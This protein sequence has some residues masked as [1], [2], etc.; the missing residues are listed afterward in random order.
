MGHIDELDI[1]HQCKGQGQSQA[2]FSSQGFHQIKE[3]HQAPHGKAPGDQAEGEDPEAQEFNE[4]NLNAVEEDFDGMG[5]TGIKIEEGF[6]GFQ[7]V[8]RN[9]GLTQTGQPGLIG[10]DKGEVREEKQTGHGVKDQS[11]KE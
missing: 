9:H 7:G 10:M 2:L 5:I 6:R 8:F 4:E 11:E 3:K 1:E